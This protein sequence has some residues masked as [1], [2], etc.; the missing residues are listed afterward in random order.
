MKVYQ[1]AEAIKLLAPNKPIILL[2]AFAPSQKPAA[3][4]LIVTKPF[5]F[6]TLREAL[7][8]MRIWQVEHALG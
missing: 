4:D 3:V 8:A 7:L 2:T 1:L 6:D 5:H